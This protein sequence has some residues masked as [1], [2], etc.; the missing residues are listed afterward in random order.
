[1]AIAIVTGASSGIGRTI[2]KYLPRY[3]DID[4]IWVIARRENLLNELKNEV[5]VPIKAVPMDLKN[6]AA[7]SELKDLIGEQQKKVGVLVNCA[8]FGKFGLYSDIDNDSA[9][10]MVDINCRAMVGITNTVLPFMESGARILQVCSI[11]S[12]QPLPLANVYAASKAF[13][14]N[15][16]RALS[17]ELKPRNITVTA[18]CPGW[19]NTEFFKTATDTKNPNA[20]TKYPFMQSPQRV[21]K[22][23]LNA[24]KRG[25][26]ITIV[27]KQNKVLYVLDKILPVKLVMKIWLK[28]QK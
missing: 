13:V 27:G 12:F 26:M 24:M 2:T 28:T 11:A 9:M 7:F 3:A 22:Q 20:V 23:A 15:Y 1:M 10:S 18:L 19:V 5:D 25:R 6:T 21:A 8:G 16:S 4:E 17:V 14:L